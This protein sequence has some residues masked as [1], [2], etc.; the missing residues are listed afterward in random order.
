MGGIEMYKRILVPLDG[1]ELAE[2]ALPYS[3]ELAEKLDSEIILINV[4][5][6][7]EDPE[8]P[9][10]KAYLSKMTATVD[11][12]IRKF[13][14]TPPGQKVKVESNIIGSSGLLTHAAEE[15]VEYA[16]KEN[17]SLIVIA[18]HGRTGIR[19]WALG[20]TADKVIRV[21]KC[22]VLLI[23]ANIDVPNK[24]NLSKFLVPLDG[25]KQSETVLSHVE[26]L[27][28]KLKARII[29]L[30]VVVPPYHIYPYTEGLGYYGSE[31]MVKVPYSAEEIKPLE[32][33]AE[34][35]LKSVSDTLMAKGITAGYEVR[36]GSA[37]E[38]IIKAADE[39]GA[40][41]VAMSTHGESGFSR[42]EH[43]SIADKVLRAGNA[44]LLLVRERQT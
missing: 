22:P 10:H 8:N 4:R 25:S 11:Q 36:V 40:D 31:G 44:P 34:K 19:R 7:G 1:S 27:A 6:P 30:H 39:A 14:N 12:N 9:E 42:W 16:E 24:I 2:I 13:S 26:S 21:A 32:A 41:I 33:V 35:Y 15:I 37:G 38:E 17:V 28:P 23:R 20:S 29:L 43:G 5:A 18:T 3:E